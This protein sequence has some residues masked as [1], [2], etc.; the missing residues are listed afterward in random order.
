[1]LFNPFGVGG[2]FEGVCGKKTCT[3]DW[4]AGL[5]LQWSMLCRISCFVLVK[6]GYED[7]SNAYCSHYTS[8]N[9]NGVKVDLRPMIHGCKLGQVLVQAR[10]RLEGSNAYSNQQ[11]S[12]GSKY[13]AG[14][15][16]RVFH[17]PSSVL[18]CCKE[19]L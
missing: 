12:A 7:F 2:G 8:D 10:Q 13:I 6:A 16:Q 18:M 9:E 5:F 4:D 19:S 1:M 14:N 17:I 11:Q 3:L 15:K